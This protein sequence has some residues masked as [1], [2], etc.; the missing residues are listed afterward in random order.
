MLIIN[1][2]KMYLI[3][4]T[5]I[6]LFVT[7]LISMLDKIESTQPRRQLKDLTNENFSDDG[8]T[9]SDETDGGYLYIDF[10]QFK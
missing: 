5:G 1:K 10:D 2:I 3:L 6:F 7:F 8:E 4:I 9:D